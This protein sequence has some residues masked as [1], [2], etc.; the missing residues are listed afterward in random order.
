MLHPTPLEYPCLTELFS[1]IASFINK[2]IATQ[3]CYME[4]QAV[5]LGIFEEQIRLKP[6]TTA[7]SH[8][9]I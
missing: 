4:D 2:K 1:K 6:Q 7:N 8:C 3:H 5:V 9:I